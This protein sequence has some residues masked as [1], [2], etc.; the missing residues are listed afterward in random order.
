VLDWRGFFF[1]AEQVE[2]RN[3]IETQYQI[4]DGPSVVRYPRGSGYGAEALL[5]L[6][7][8][9]IL[10]S[11]SPQPSEDPNIAIADVLRAYDSTGALRPGVRGRVLPVGKGRIVKHRAVRNRVTFDCKI[12]RRFSFADVYIQA[13]RKYRLCV[14]S[15][16]TRLVESVAAARS[17]EAQFPAAGVTVADARFLKPLDEQL[18][19]ALAQSHDALVTVEEGSAG[20]FG[21]QVLHFLSDSGLLDQGRLRVRSM[22]VPD[23]WIEAGPQQD[24]YDIAGLN[25]QH[26]AQKLDDLLYL[27]MNPL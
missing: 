7:S 18:L 26:I 17:L 1:L 3:M 23:V 19:R 10:D 4:G 6:H 12:C 2:L 27:L 11:A 5:D 8:D 13:G 15:L 20:G 21:A 14:V 16:G 25:R 22:H 24:Q 9:A